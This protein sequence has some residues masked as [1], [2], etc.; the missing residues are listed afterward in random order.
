MY[1]LKV[2]RQA[3]GF[4]QSELADAAGVP[5]RMIR[6][7]EAEAVTA[8]KD[9]NRAEA[10]TVYKLALALK[11]EVPDLLELDSDEGNM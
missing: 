6:A 9:I 7:Y 5:I 1:N 11:C 4:S 2:K 10:L 8:H 3:A